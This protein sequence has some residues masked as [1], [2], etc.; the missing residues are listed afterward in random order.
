M[1]YSL[2]IKDIPNTGY[3]RHFKFLKEFQ[4]FVPNQLKE[5]K[6]IAQYIQ[7]MDK[8]ILSLQEKKA[9][10]TQ[11]KQGM[12]QSLLTGKIRLV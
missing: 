6:E 7:D 12:M 4:Y 5:Q 3:N 1:Y 10:Y 2:L 11:I 8:E 9:K